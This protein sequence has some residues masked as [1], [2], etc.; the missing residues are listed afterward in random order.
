M[1]THEKFLSFNGKNIV[2]LNKDG[3]YWIAIKPICEALDIDYVSQYKNLTIDE[4]YV[5]ALSKQTM[6]DS[7]NRRQE[8]VCINERNVYGWIASINS[9]NEDFL[10]YKRTCYDILYSHFHGIITNRK[11]L[12]LNQMEIDSRIYEIKEE[13]QLANDQ[14]KELEQLKL[15]KKAIKKDLKSID[16]EL[17]QTPKLF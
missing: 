10:K 12:L 3:Q 11:E 8:M 9:K 1:N 2:F 13:L 16:E 17:I 5:N 14:F 15:R 7:S 4:F 6:H